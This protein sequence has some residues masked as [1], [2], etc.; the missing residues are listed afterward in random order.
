M[1][2][3]PHTDQEIAEMLA[4]I[5][6]DSLSE[7]FRSVPPDALLAGPLNLPEPMDELTLTGRMNELARRNR[8]A[9]DLVSFLGA[10][11]Y[12]HFS[13]AVVD[14]LA[15][16]SEFATAYTPYQP[17]LSQGMLQA[18]YE[19]QSLMCALTGMDIANASM[20]DG[21]TAMAEAAL[22]LVETTGHRRVGVSRA[23]HPHYRQVIRTYCTAADVECVEIGCENGLTDPEAV[24]RVVS[25][26]PTACAVVQHPNFLGYLED[27][28][29]VQSVCASAGV[30]T[31]VSADPVSL[32]LLKPPGDF[33]VDVVVGEGQPLGLPMG[34]GGPLLGFF[35]CRQEY[36]RRFPG[37]IVGRTHDGEG[38][39]GY[40]MTLRTREQDIRREK[41]TSNICTNEALLALAATVHLCVLG[42]VGLRE[43]AELCLQKSHYALDTLANI[44]GVGSAFS[45]PFVKEFVIRLDT[46]RAVHDVCTALRGHGIIAGLPLGSYYPELHDCLLVCV[47]ERRTKAEIDM[48]AD[49]LNTVMEGSAR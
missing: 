22:M 33:G 7:L 41:A 9:D 34:F 40:T 28:Q 44:F 3:T 49:R 6:V 30:K 46:R 23:L 17:E 48:F 10:G 18:M 31:V 4:V 29:G 20:Y 43:T 25:E 37:R 42:P 19:F 13:P 12:D 35:A 39:P 45:A 32:A 2:Y 47:T 24:Q 26:A 8:S 11:I 14:A 1:S 38:R 27:L 5:G 16:R 15:Y 36:Q 21:A